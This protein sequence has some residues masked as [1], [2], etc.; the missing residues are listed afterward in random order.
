ML[1]ASLVKGIALRKI[2]PEC[3]D[4]GNPK[5]G[6]GSSSKIPIEHLLGRLFE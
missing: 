1:L 6:A 4:P 3:L 5:A 2:L